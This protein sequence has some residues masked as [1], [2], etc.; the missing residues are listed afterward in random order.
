MAYKKLT[1][2]DKRKLRVRKKVKGSN[3]C[4]RFLVYRSNRFLYAQVIDDD[5]QKTLVSA[6]TLK[7]QK[8]CNK[9]AG[10]ML[11]RL[12]ADKALEQNIKRVVFDRGPNRYHGVIKEIADSAREAGLQF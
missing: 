3:E 8:S 10:K 11:G 6:S 2:K 5:A 1:A 7:E 4:P 12:L 9:D